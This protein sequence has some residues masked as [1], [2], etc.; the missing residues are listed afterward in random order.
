MRK[1]ATIAMTELRSFVQTKAFLIS[2]IIMPLLMFGGGFIGEKLRGLDTKTRKFAVIDHTGEL[3][4]AIDR[5]AAERDRKIAA[6]EQA[7]RFV[8]TLVKAD[9][10]SF[11][12]LRLSISDAI[13]REEYFALIEIPANVNAEAAQISYSSDSPTYDALRD[14]VDKVLARE[15]RMNRYK[16]AGLSADTVKVIER[17]LQ[18]SN[19]GLW[20]RN[21]DGKVIAAA[22]VDRMR[23]LIVPAGTFFLLFLLVM[24]GAPHLLHAVIEEKMSR[25][26]EVLLGAVTPFQLMM[27]KLVGNAAV[28]ILLAGVYITGGLSIAAKLGY[29]DLF[30]PAI[31]AYFGLFLT[32]ATFLYGALYLAI[33]AACNDIKEAQ[34]FLTPVVLVMTLPALLFGS[35]FESPSSQLSVAASLF[36]TS[37]PFIMLMR[38]GLH[39]A[40]PVWQVALSIALTVSATICCVWVAGKIFRTGLLLQGKAPS[41]RELARW[42][43]SA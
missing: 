29:G 30:P 41:L 36:P 22:P 32:L 34:T 27:G 19:L 9:S 12:D 11:D 6:G 7:A 13:K 26:S 20:Q 43:V 14:W 37:A 39:P 15:V 23:L 10:G 18:T 17:P 5:A 2:V 3:Y 28:S 4:G 38:L 33:G 35:I 24:I 40:P 25:I 31:L 8:P 42:V 16:T 21:A 1:I